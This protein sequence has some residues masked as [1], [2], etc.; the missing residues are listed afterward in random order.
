MALCIG[1]APA[2]AQD[3]PPFDPEQLA[4]ESQGTIAVGG[5]A[6]GTLDAAAAHWWTLPL[7]HGDTIFVTV[8]A[9]TD[10]A[11][12]PVVRLVDPGGNL[13]ALDDNLAYARNAIIRQFTAQQDDDYFL[14]IADARQNGGLYTV[15][16]G[17]LPAT[18]EG[19]PTLTPI[20][21]TL[22]STATATEASASAPTA[23]PQPTATVADQRET[24][25][26]GQVIDA[27]L[28]AGERHSYIIEGTGG[29]PLVIDM[30]LPAEGADTLDPYLELYGPSG[31]L[32]FRNDDAVYGKLDA[33]LDIKLPTTATYTLI[34]RSLGDRGGGAYRLT[35]QVGALWQ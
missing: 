33:R 31:D 29:M 7:A 23:A 22:P 11:I 30:T 21:V 17:R 3:P 1:G 25:H 32:L 28:G 6:E 19:Q 14:G 12:A 10:S 9:G 35:V 4:A 34:A 26:V 16:I 13:V 20:A 18:P 2:A 5:S 8:N 24:L 15:F 27:T